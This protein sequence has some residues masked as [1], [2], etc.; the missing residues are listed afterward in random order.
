MRVQIWA[1][2]T[3]AVGRGTLQRRKPRA[4]WEEAAVRG[5][6]VRRG[7]RRQLCSAPVPVGRP[8]RL[9]HVRQQS[10][11][12][13][14]AAAGQVEASKGAAQR[15]AGALPRPRS[16]TIAALHLVNQPRVSAQLISSH[17]AL[18]RRRC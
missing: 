13:R 2:A 7:R 1:G 3:E 9:V 6:G 15:R 8:L 4:R 14:P 11:Q 17:T 5:A 16:C 12:H 18:L 10:Q